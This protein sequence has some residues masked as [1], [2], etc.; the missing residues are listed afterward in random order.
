MWID[1]VLISTSGVVASI[2]SRLYHATTY[3]A[4][5]NILMHNYFRSTSGIGGT[6]L[7][8]TTDPH[9]WWGSKEVRFVI[10]ARKISRVW[11]TKMVDERLMGGKLKESEVLIMTDR[12]I[13]NIDKYLLEIQYVKTVDK[14]SRRTH[15]NFIHTLN[16]YIDKFP[17]VTSRKI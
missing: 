5:T 9:Y 3:E 16:E 12:A 11:P 4:A 14:Y 2:A 10:D 15:S 6:G 17:H 1:R 7:S 13:T 8:T